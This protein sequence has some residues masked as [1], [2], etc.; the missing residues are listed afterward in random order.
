MLTLEVRRRPG[1]SVEMHRIPGLS[2]TVGA[3]SGNE[4]VVR[5]RGVYG[6][7]LRLLQKDGAY[8]LDLFRGISPVQV[9]GHEFAGGTIAPGDR[10]TIGEATITVVDAAPASRS[11][12]AEEASTDSLDAADA[13]SA[14]RRDRDRAV[15]RAVVPARH[16]GRVPSAASVRLSAL[17]GGAERRGARHRADGFPRPGA[18]ADGVGG[19]RVLRH[20]RIPTARLD[21]PGD[22]GA[23]APDGA[24]DP[25][26]RAAGALG[27]RDRGID[28]RR[29]ARVR[30]NRQRRHSRARVAASGRAG[31]ALRR[32]A[33]PPRRGRVREPARP[34]G[35][36]DADGA[37]RRPRPPRRR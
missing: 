6:R 23:A 30:G 15:R 24:G 17:P 28:A 14:R 18:A 20:G 21:V 33:L 11:L 22:P 9:N 5:A 35:R 2:A 31:G 34:A 8:H 3:S 10:I 37:C 7:H 16:R 1:T 26:G 36:A 29:R 19:R 27:E 13:R 12:G 4:V 32:G 25:L